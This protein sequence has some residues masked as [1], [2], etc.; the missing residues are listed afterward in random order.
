MRPSTD[1]ATMPRDLLAKILS[2]LNDVAF[3]AVALEEASSMRTFMLAVPAACTEWRTVCRHR[4]LARISFKWCCPPLQ[5]A[6]RILG[7]FKSVSALT[8]GSAVHP[9]LMIAWL[10]EGFGLNRLEGFSL[11]GLGETLRTNSDRG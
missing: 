6:S 9:D 2:H 10:V 4:I 8:L 7:R 5:H 1:W 3:A 11:F